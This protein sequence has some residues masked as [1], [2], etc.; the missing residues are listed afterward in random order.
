MTQSVLIIGSNGGIGSSLFRLMSNLTQYCITGWTSQNLNLNYPEQIFATDLSTYDI[1]VNCTGHNQGGW[2]G[3]LKNTWQ[4]QLSII[5][6]NYISNVFLL[7]HYANNRPNGYYVWLNTV[8]IDKPTPYQS[9]YTGAKVA[10]EFSIDLIAKEAPHITVLT[11]K[12]GLVDTNFRY[13]NFEGTK[14]RREILD[15]YIGSEIMSANDV[16]NAL[17]MAITKNKKE[18][19]IT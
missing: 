7:K 9:I 15:S 8:L 3:T 11:A 10:S 12:V 13:R 19:L 4:N 18:V 16:A 14:T 1:V 17:L 5:T 6:V 2:M